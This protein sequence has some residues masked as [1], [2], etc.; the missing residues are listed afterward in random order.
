MKITI[1]STNN[2][3]LRILGKVIFIGIRPQEY[4]VS[5]RSER[6]DKLFSTIFQCQMIWKGLNW[7]KRTV[8]ILWDF[9]NFLIL[10]IAYHRK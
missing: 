8:V 7:E 10:S 9:T 5:E 1:G 4:N 6:E 2:T 3:D